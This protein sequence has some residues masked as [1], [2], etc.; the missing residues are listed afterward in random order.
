MEY[1]SYA[2]A[3]LTSYKTYNCKLWEI[4]NKF[5]MWSVVHEIYWKIKFFEIIMV[6]FYIICFETISDKKLWFADIMKIHI[7]QN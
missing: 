3:H 7:R 6:Y 4:Q 1:Y 5:T 2:I